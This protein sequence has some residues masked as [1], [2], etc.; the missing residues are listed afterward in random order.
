MKEN[1]RSKTMFESCEKYTLYIGLNDQ[2][3]KTQLIDTNEARHIVEDIFYNKIGGA[4]ISLARGIYKHDDGTRVLENTIRV[5]C[6]GADYTDIVYCAEYLKK[7]FNQESIAVNK[8][9][10]QSVFM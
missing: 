10:V 6:F 1:E 2:Q 3:T 4:T 8:E 9:I 5:E 7:A